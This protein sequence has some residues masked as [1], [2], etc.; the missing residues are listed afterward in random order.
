M[1]KNYDYVLQEN[2]NDCGVASLM[3]VL[4][5]YGI[6]TSREKLLEELKPNNEGITA[7]D[8]IRV[9]K[10]YGLDG[11]G[12]KSIPMNIESKLLPAI[13][14]TIKNKN[15]YHYIVILENDIKNK[16]LKIMDPSIGI[17]NITYEKFKEIST[18]IFILFNSENIFKEKDK[19]FKNILILIYKSNKKL[20]LKT[21]SFSVIFIFISIIYN[22]YL[23]ILINV[24]NIKLSY[25]IL[26]LFI[27]IMLFKNII[28]YLKNII[29]L[30]LNYSIDKKITKKV[31]SHIVHLPYKY[32]KS[33]KVG[34]LVTIINDIENFKD[35][36]TNIFVL[37]LIDVFLMIIV[38]I[39][40]SC[41]NLLYGLILLIFIFGYV[42]ITKK[43]QYIFN[44]IY[45]KLKKK[46]INYNSNLVNSL[47]SFDSIKNLNIENRVIKNITNDY[48]EVL[49]NNKNYSTKYYNYNLLTN[50]L[51]DLSF[52][53]ISFLTLIILNKLGE[54]ISKIIL[55][56]NLFNIVFNFMSSI[57]EYLVMRKIYQTSIDKVLDI[58]DVKEEEFNNSRIDNID[59]IEFK[60]VSYDIDNK[61]ILNNVKL[62]INKKDHIFI[63]GKSGIG[64]STMMR[65]LLRYDEVKDGEI[66]IDNININNL[67]LSF[68]RKNITY[69]SQNESLLSNTLLENLTIVCSNKKEVDKAC[70]TVLLDTLFTNGIIDYNLFL[71][72]N[73][74]NISG[75][76]RK[77]IILARALLKRSKVLILDEVFNEIDVVEERKILNNIFKNYKDL[78]VIVISHRDNN[79]NLFNKIYSLKE[80]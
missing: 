24:S 13:A 68:I 79:I 4:L 50:L 2:N 35:I 75:G 1:I 33:K 54:D 19:R 9:S 62:T 44:D 71:E 42:I 55:L 31:I 48:K 61:N 53:I 30:K 67:D 58:L 45:V 76:Q 78:T 16:T 69:V 3:T 32:Y 10:N 66:L 49:Y 28:D 39:Y 20:I 51:T 15:F 29:M 65:L 60:N 40:I 52:I 14:H 5:C 80:E 59:K 38:L 74:S 72:E 22:Y 27:N 34:E 12:V 47:Y 43:Y 8:L 57:S 63:K 64:K 46:K 56:C 37:S 73:G 17:M 6:K 23:T 70:K 36:V 11:Y 26:F 77:K 25:L 7:Y 41:Y 18:N 21:I